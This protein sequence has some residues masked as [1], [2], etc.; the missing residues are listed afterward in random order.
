MAESAAENGGNIARAYRSR[1]IARRAHKRAMKHRAQCA[2]ARVRIRASRVM[3]VAYGMAKKINGG[4]INE[5]KNEN[6]W[7]RNGEAATAA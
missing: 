2:Y 4:S 1:V 5:M 3:R 6:Q 7:R